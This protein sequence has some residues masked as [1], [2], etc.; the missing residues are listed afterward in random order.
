LSTD[1]QATGKREAPST[2][3]GGLASIHTLPLWVV[4]LALAGSLLVLLVLMGRLNSTLALMSDQVVG[5]A[6]F[7][8][9]T[10]DTTTPT[11][12]PANCTRT[13]GFWKTH[14]QVWPLQTVAIGGVTY[15]QEQAL[16]I[17]KISPDGDA[18]FLLAQQLIAARLNIAAGANPGAVANAL[19]QAD[20]WL[21]ANP[22]GSDPGKPARNFGI[23]LAGQL[24]RYNNGE[25]GPGACSDDGL[26]PE[27]PEQDELR[28]VGSAAYWLANRER[29]PIQEAWIGGVL[30]SLAEAQLLLEQDASSDLLMQIRQQVLVIRLN[31]ASGAAPGIWL[32]A[33]DQADR[34]LV[35]HSDSAL[36]SPEERQMTAQYILILGNFNDGMLDSPSCKMDSPPLTPTRTAS[37]ILLPTDTALLP[38]MTIGVSE[39][40]A[41]TAPPTGIV[42]IERSPTPIPVE[43]AAPHPT[44]TPRRRPGSKDCT[45]PAEY[46]LAHPEAWPLKALYL[47]DRLRPLRE[48]LSL[49]EDLPVEDTP[50]RLT[51]QLVAAQLNLAQGANPSAI[52]EALAAAEVWIERN[53]LGNALR[54]QESQ[55][56]V[57]LAN[58]LQ[59]F[60]DGLVGPGLCELPSPV[61]TLQLT[62]T[63]TPSAPSP[64]STPSPA[65]PFAL[66][67]PTSTSTPADQLTQAPPVE[68]PP[69]TP[70]RDLQPPPTPLEDSPPLAP[71]EGG[72]RSDSPE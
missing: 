23:R 31:L 11:P 54:E 44:R 8:A 43:S 1:R 16:A 46:W 7:A 56:A 47:G 66:A 62:A 41:D 20:E 25:I 61:P 10:W 45:Y 15:T 5:E 6:Q 24:D 14:P 12:T 57:E 70:T 49:L 48:L 22:L 17:L 21:V 40:P 33:I 72:V 42:T 51:R 34:W 30:Y 67:T 50:A 19:Q 64:T 65:L 37:M 3:A 2:Q 38:T 36:L 52:A 68:P 59:A 58:S 27:P 13:H 71:S 55:Q 69:A 18:T 35:A 28:C 26:T 29:W 60:N 39:T 32:E 4:G 63:G 9:A 53:P